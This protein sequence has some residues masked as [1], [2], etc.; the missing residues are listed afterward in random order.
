MDRVDRMRE[1]ARELS[2]RIVKAKGFMNSNE[3]PQVNVEDRMLLE[4]QVGYMRRYLDI[5]SERIE[6]AK[7]E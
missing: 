6:R 1:E 5:L 4:N 2:A 3:F 7:H